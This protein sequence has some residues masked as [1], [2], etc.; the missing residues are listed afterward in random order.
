MITVSSMN[1][2]GPLGPVPTPSRPPGPHRRRVGLT[3]ATMLCLV[4]TLLSGC[5]SGSGGDIGTSAP[6]GI[7]STTAVSVRPSP[8]PSSS[9]A[10]PQTPPT[11]GVVVPFQ[12]VAPGS[13]IGKRFGLVSSAGSDPF[14]KAVTDSV[15]AQ[16]S[17]AG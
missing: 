8:A 13:A 6:T 9:P 7:G 2:P 10:S 14:G 11:T 3:A 5:S 12:T 16:V 4:G 17:A 15:V 1:R